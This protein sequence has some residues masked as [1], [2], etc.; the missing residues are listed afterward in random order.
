M[1]KNAV[2]VSGV[3]MRF[4]LARERV[5][6]LKEYMIRALKKNMNYDEFYAL[7][8]V[9]FKIQKGDSFAIIGSNG[10]G[11]S[12]LLKIIS[13]IFKPTTG[14][15]EVNGSIA[16][17]IELG[18]GFDMELTARE[19]I[20]LNGAVLG[21]S[22]KFILEKYDEIISFSELHNFVDVPLKNFSSGMVARLGF[23]IATMVQPD[24]LIVDEILS[25]GDYSFQEKCEKRMKEMTDNGTTLILVSHS[26]EQVK[27]VCNNAVL[28]REGEL[29]TIGP[30]EDVSNL[31]L[32]G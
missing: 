9:S 6:S 24:I 8:D 14:K 13:G 21:Y 11:K 12:T 31:Y 1:T 28:I 26:I 32:N 15:V 17:L 4:N 10:S 3:S 30:I 22:K 25:V 2:E 16:P 19:N 27:K 7:K 23:S 20:F 5:D 18:A 29:V